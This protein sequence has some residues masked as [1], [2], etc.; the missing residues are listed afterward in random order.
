MKTVKSLTAILLPA[1][2]ATTPQTA[3]AGEAKTRHAVKFELLST[4]LESEYGRAAILSRMKQKARVACRNKPSSSYVKYTR[5][6]A[7]DLM[8]QWIAAIGSSSLTAQAY[9]GSMQI[10]FADK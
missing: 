5:T 3:F 4:E 6:C 7:P 8:E 9:S 2:V 1:I 10:A